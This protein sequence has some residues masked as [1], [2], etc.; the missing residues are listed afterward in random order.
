MRGNENGDGKPRTVSDVLYVVVMT[1][2]PVWT[3]L[4]FGAVA[5][6]LCRLHLHF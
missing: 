1:I 6:L 5:V 2:G 3:A 4:I